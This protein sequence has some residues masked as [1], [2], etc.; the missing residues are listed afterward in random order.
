MEKNPRHIRTVFGAHA[1]LDGAG[2]HRAAMFGGLP[3]QHPE[4]HPQN[5]RCIGSVIENIRAWVPASIFV[6]PF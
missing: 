1:T 2:S 6:H 3:Q 4:L 5:V